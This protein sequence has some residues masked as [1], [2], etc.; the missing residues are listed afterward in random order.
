MASWGRR[1]ATLPDG[2]RMDSRSLPEP[3]RRTSYGAGSPVVGERGARTRAHIVQV[4][5]GLMGTKGAHQTT[6][7]DIAG[8]VGVSRATLYQYFESKEQIFSELVE[9]SGAALLRVVRR[10]GPLGPDSVGFARLRAWMVD[11]AAIYAR[12]SEVFAQWSAVENL[13]GSRQSMLATWM[14]NYVGRVTPLLAAAGPSEVDPSQLAVAVWA[15]FERYSSLMSA[16]PDGEMAV[17]DMAAVAQLMLFPGTPVSVLSESVR[18]RPPPSVRNSPTE[19]GLR[20]EPRYAARFEGVGPEARRTAERILDAG[21]R[22]FTLAGFHAVSVE[23]VATAAEVGRGTFYK[24]FDSKVDLLGALGLECSRRMIAL[25]EALSERLVGERP[26][27]PLSAWLEEFVAFHAVFG[28]VWRVWTD[29]PSLSASSVEIGEVARDALQRGLTRLARATPHP[30]RLAD[31]S[32]AAMLG[33]LLQRFPDQ[34]RG[35]PYECP[36]QELVRVLQLL[37][38]RALLP[39]YPSDPS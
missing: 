9:E 26:R 12:Y 17:A 33:G 2:W 16:H 39:V 22:L 3:I 31:E 27:R 34:A 29:E 6:M 10:A 11:W 20:I 7:D 5:L 23:Q 13:Q 38:E 30:Y 24:Y 8:A 1:L 37:I 14:T 15:L 18:S 32:V 35:T 36:P 19:A 28:G 4:A 25:G 21:G